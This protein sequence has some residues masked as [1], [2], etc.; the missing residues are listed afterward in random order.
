MEPHQEPNCGDNKNHGPE[1]RKGQIQQQGGE[2]TWI[3]IECLAFGEFGKP[4]LCHFSENQKGAAHG[5][6]GEENNDDAPARVRR[7]I[8]V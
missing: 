7:N 2:T 3:V 6:G 5:V 4:K 8:A 1:N